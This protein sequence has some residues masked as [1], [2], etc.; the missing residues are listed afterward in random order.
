MCPVPGDRRRLNGHPPVFSFGAVGVKTPTKLPSQIEIDELYELSG[1]AASQTNP[2]LYAINDSGGKPHIYAIRENG[3]SFA[4][5][6]VRGHN[7]DWESLCVATVENQEYIIVADTGSFRRER[8]RLLMIKEPLL[9]KDSTIALRPSWTI[10]LAY[11]NDDRLDIESLA[12][13]PQTGTAFLLSKAKRKKGERDWDTSKKW[14]SV[15]T[16][17]TR[18]GSVRRAK[19]VTFNGVHIEARIGSVPT[20]IDFSPDGKLLAILTYKHAYVIRR[21]KGETWERALW[22]G[23][24]EF[25]NCRVEI[26]E[27]LRLKQME[28]ICFTKDG[29]AILISTETGRHGRHA[30]MLRAEVEIN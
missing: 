27:H 4:T 24:D 13:D 7:H 23:W 25:E 10:E 16:S 5:I 11:P 6:E 14:Y 20:G 19:P 30:S 12:V 9:T 18:K 17:P 22:K 28:S 2:C 21:G 1:L 3:T 26:P 8:P 15:S 29:K